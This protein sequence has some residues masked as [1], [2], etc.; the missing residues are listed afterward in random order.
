MI[1]RSVTK[2]IGLIGTR[3]LCTV[4]KPYGTKLANMGLPPDNSMWQITAE[5]QPFSVPSNPRCSS[6]QLQLNISDHLPG[7]F[8]ATYTSLFSSNF[9][10]PSPWPLYNQFCRPMYP[11]HDN[12]RLGANVPDGSKC[13]H[14]KEFPGEASLLNDDGSLKKDL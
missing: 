14:T 8:Q 4:K 5:K 7:Y 2:G 12:S 11:R 6:G 3:T 9:R 13:L 1:D 10:P